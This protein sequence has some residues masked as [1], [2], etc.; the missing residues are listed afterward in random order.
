MTLPLHRHSAESSSS[1]TAPTCIEQYKVYLQHAIVNN[2]SI[3][4]D[5]SDQKTH[6]RRISNAKHVVPNDE[7][8]C[9]RQRPQSHDPRRTHPKARPIPSRHE[10]RLLRMQSERL[11]SPARD[12][13]ATA[14]LTITQEKSRVH[15]R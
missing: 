3:R 14:T 15:A 12:R 4:K 8:S 6:Y 5:S 7:R 13:R 9:C 1:A 11:V 10:S 2:A